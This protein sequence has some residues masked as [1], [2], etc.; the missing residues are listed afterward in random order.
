[1]FHIVQSI[2]RQKIQRIAAMNMVFFILY[3]QGCTTTRSYH[4][5]P[6]HLENKAEIPGFHNIR[7]WAD[8]HSKSLEKSVLLSAAQEKAHNHGQ[9]KP[10]I[11]SLVLSGGGKDGAFGAGFLCGWSKTGTRP[12]FKV[13]TGISTGALMAPYAFLG[14]EYD[15]Q[16]K[17]VYTTVSDKDIYKPRSIFANLLGLGNIIPTTSLTDNKPIVQLIKRSVDASMLQKIAAEHA[18]GRRLFVGTTQ[19][20]AQRLVIWDMGAIASSKSPQA[21]A[22]FRKILVASSALPVL[23]PPQYFS[24][25]AEGKMYTEMHVDGGVE[26]EAIYSENAIIPHQIRKILKIRKPEH[27]LY[28][29]R[30]GKVSPQWTGVKRKLDSMIIT[31]LD[32]LIKSQGIS[33]LY[34]LYTYSL[35]DGIDYNLAYIPQDFAIEAE[36]P[37]DKEY[38]NKLFLRG[39]VLGKSGYKWKKHPPNYTP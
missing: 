18:K 9:L 19:F 29:I 5:L 24:V 27:K 8:E 1:M 30:N 16:L 11:N 25:V 34:R 23:F 37:F 33:D 38:M 6:A 39:Y 13:V 21:L 14:P 2:N 12:Q 10:Q 35:R 17:K 32:S 28:I 4:P 7:G 22:L 15:P 31:T 36:T 20:N 3:L 26:S